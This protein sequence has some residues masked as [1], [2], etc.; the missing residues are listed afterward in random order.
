MNICIFGS[1]VTCG[2]YDEE[3]GGWV[4]R[5][6]FLL[7][8]EEDFSGNVFNFGVS[9][10]NTN[11]LLNLF[12]V[13]TQKIKPDIIIFSLSTN[14]P[15]FLIKENKFKIDLEDY[16]KNLNKLSEKAKKITEKVIFINIPPVDDQ[17]T[18]PLSW[19]DNK[20]I[21][22]E[23]LEKYN[24]EIKNF[25]EKN[26]IKFIDIYSKMKKIDYKSFLFDG[27][28]PNSEGHKWMAGIILG[29]IRELIKIKK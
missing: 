10:A 12:D 23:N 1:S 29:E 2:R 24:N 13:E 18:N 7:E 22:N 15:S 26:G 14:D 11:N 27:L 20:V 17:K 16:K 9:G 4:N 25:C 5:I 3:M 8:N 6:K 28:H 21:L 19:N